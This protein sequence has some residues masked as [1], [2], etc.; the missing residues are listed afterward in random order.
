MS[1]PTD[2]PVTWT[3]NTDVIQC[4]LKDGET[5]KPVFVKYNTSDSGIIEL[6]V[7]QPVHN[8]PRENFDNL[9]VDIGEFFGQFRS[10]PDYRDYQG[11]FCHTI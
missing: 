8:E 7:V 11:L 9:K 10:K 6:K 1:N 5:T 3:A 4:Y 2:K